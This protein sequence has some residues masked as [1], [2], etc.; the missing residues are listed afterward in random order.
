MSDID[1]RLRHV[2]RVQVPELW[3]GIETREPRPSIP[4]E[5]GGRIASI[6]L[7]LVVSAAGVFLAARAFV[8][9]SNQDVTSAGLQG[10]NTL[11]IPPRG[12]A[13]PEFLADGHP[14]WVIHH[15][16]DSLSVLDAF[17]THVPFGIEELI[18]WCDSAQR[19]QEPAH[20]ASFN[21]Y[22]QYLDG[23]APADLAYFEFERSGGQVRVR[24][25]TV[26]ETRTEGVTDPSN[27][28]LCSAPGAFPLTPT[29]RVHHIPSSSQLAS[30]AAAVE[31]RPSGWFAVRGE[32]WIRSGA[33]TLLCGVFRATRS[34]TTCEAE[35]LVA[36][37]SSQKLLDFNGLE[38]LSIEGQWLAR[39]EG[40]HLT[41]LTDIDRPAEERATAPHPIGSCIQVGPGKSIDHWEIQKITLP[42]GALASPRVVTIT[43]NT[44][45]EV[46]TG[47][48][49]SFSGPVSVTIVGDS[50]EVLFG[51][52][53]G[54][55]CSV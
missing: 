54:S 5:H 20:G 52:Q 42:E 1:R 55:P 4:P 32:L 44:G 6:L 50:V 39:V 38:E 31:A 21:E 13:S 17:S 10:S 22:G 12:E 25:I 9:P 27:M 19:F 2:D 15:A 18:G 37:V 53:V 16:D 35:A 30:P 24:D 14:V 46:S 41:S 43:L 45:E 36:G 47:L 51:D 26:P 8:S 48:P 34:E 29:I 49:A 40:D 11:D 33:P 3:D 28:P 23:P 7:A